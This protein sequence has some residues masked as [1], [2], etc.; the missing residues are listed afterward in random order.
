[1]TIDTVTLAAPVPFLAPSIEYSQLAP[2][3]IVFA[4]AT[5]GVTI[6]AFAPRRLRHRAQV[7]LSLVSLVAAFLAVVAIAGT[8]NL[9]AEGALAIDG[10]T[11]FLQGTIVALAAVALLTVAERSLDAE[12]GPFTPQAAALPG[13]PWPWSCLR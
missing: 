13:S 8:E 9:A 12:G 4:A 7:V 3:L 11:L 10:P 1:M 2:M 6:E 5:V